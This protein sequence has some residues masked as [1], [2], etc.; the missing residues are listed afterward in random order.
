M[1]PIESTT[2]MSNGDGIDTGLATTTR[3]EQY[4][5]YLHRGDHTRDRHLRIERERFEKGTGI[6]TGVMGNDNGPGSGWTG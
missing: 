2:R 4:R 1:P 6:Y 5:Y 3:R